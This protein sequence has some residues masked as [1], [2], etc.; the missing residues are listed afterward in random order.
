[1]IRVLLVEDHSMVLDG[2]RRLLETEPGFAVAGVARDVAGALAALET[3]R[4]DVAIIDL[5]L[6]DGSGLEVAKTAGNRDPQV[7]CVIL[8]AQLSAYDL[9]L[10]RRLKVRGLV[11]KEDAFAA[12]TRCV[13][14][15]ASGGISFPSSGRNDAAN[16]A[17]D[18]PLDLLTPREL[19]IARLTA[20]GLRTREVG[21][22]LDISP[23]TVKI[24][25]SR[26]Y[27]KLS[28]TSR[29]ELANLLNRLAAG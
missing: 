16:A 3:G 21:A 19:E 6:P 8:T 1:M 12:L 25:L 5:R 2:L 24:H 26:V 29:V 20:D 9:T 14:I 7:R 28:I 13:R 15:V 4:F 22:L 10:A 11:M 18:M 23:G 17:L 27:D